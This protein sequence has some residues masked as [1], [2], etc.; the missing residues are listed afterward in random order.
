MC[1]E[2]S[3]LYVP[4]HWQAGKGRQVRE[5]WEKTR[6]REGEVPGQDRGV[7]LRSRDERATLDNLACTRR[8]AREA[9]FA[10]PGGGPMLDRRCRTT[11]LTVLMERVG[12]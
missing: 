2:I 5:S 11:Y 8:F 1:C 4:G 12:K 6:C 10:A 9:G 7:N 3:A